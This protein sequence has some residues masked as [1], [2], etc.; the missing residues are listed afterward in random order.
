MSPIQ[1]DGI[2]KSHLSWNADKPRSVCLQVFIPVCVA[3]GSTVRSCTTIFR[4]RDMSFGNTSKYNVWTTPT[5]NTN[6]QRSSWS[7]H[8]L[9]ALLSTLRKQKWESTHQI[10]QDSWYISYQKIIKDP[11][12]YTIHPSKCHQNLGPSSEVSAGGPLAG[13]FPG[14]FTGPFLSSLSVVNVSFWKH[15]KLSTLR[16]I[17]ST[18]SRRGLTDCLVRKNPNHG[19]MIFHKLSLLLWY[20]G[21]WSTPFVSNGAQKFNVSNWFLLESTSWVIRKGVQPTVSPVNFQ[22]KHP[23]SG[24]GCSVAAGLHMHEKRCSMTQDVI[25]TQVLALQFQL[26]E[27]V[28]PSRDLW[29]DLFQDPFQDPS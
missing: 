21:F 4:T 28:V 22:G 23:A 2:L 7:I 25:R 26:Q 10:F 27:Q 18:G 19:I 1:L 5:R 9:Q 11:M 6:N 8:L 15:L 13:P 20:A 14:P 29:R 16:I 17:L 12:K 3:L 24:C